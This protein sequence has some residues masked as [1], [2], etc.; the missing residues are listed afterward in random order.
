MWLA[1]LLTAG[2][3][4]L[5][6]CGGG[7]E[8]SQPSPEASPEPRQEG[9]V[10]STP[11]L[12][13]GEPCRPDP[14]DP[15]PLGEPGGEPSG[16]IMFVRLSSPD[17]EI[18]VIKADGSDETNVSRN[19]APDDEP[20][21]SP[22]GQQIV[23]FSDRDALGANLYVMDADGGDARRITDGGADVSPKWS[24]DGK[25]IAFSR[26]GV[27]SVMNADGSN[28]QV[29]MQPQPVQTVEPCRAGSF[30]GGWSP[31]GQRLVYY[32]ALIRPG[33]ENTFWVCAMD[34]DGSNI[35]VLVEAPKGQLHAEPVWSPDGR[36]IA[37]RD[38]RDGNYD[39]YVLD[40]ETGE[41]INVSDSPAADIE[42]A[43]SPDGQWIAFGSMREG[44][45]NF[46]IYIM[47]AD[48]TDLRRLTDHLD[49]DSYPVWTR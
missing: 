27:L 42:P 13:A 1:G 37:F 8:E 28:L 32:S 34:A 19:S 21:W 18:M 39:I 11:E 14:T 38:D 41:E 35:T 46:D 23:F 20:D 22:D 36:R 12:E 5:T 44:S 26:G 17:R 16:R 30:V 2:L 6:A 4:L 25:C 7:E 45:P 49:K 3:L 9:T 48:G 47:R 24:P 10:I 40:L 29:I 33:G 15:M 43:W 31:D